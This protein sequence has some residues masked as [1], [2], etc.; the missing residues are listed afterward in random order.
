MMSFPSLSRPSAQCRREGA[1]G[2]HL[3]TL[4]HLVIIDN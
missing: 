4:A 3:P 1:I 2:K